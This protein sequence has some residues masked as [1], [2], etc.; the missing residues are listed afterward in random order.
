MAIPIKR[1][2]LVHNHNFDLLEWGAKNSDNAETV[3]VCFKVN[4]E[5]TDSENYS[6][7]YRAS[8]FG[9]IVRK[10][11]RTDNPVYEDLSTRFCFMIG[12]RENKDLFEKQVL[13]PSTYGLDYIA[14]YEEITTI[15]VKKRN[16]DV[17]TM[18]ADDLSA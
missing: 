9:M 10:S 13:K 5:L 15:I 1:M 17:L 4:P 11:H 14:A 3:T 8:V 7:D 2:L 12:D 6:V 18:N 16:G